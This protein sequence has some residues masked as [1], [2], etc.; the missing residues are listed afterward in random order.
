M[1]LGILAILYLVII[2]AVL[3]FQI[4]LYKPNTKEENKVV[5]FGLNIIL[6]FVL[7]Y[8]VYS[9]LPSNYTIQKVLPLLWTGLAVIAF[10]IKINTHK[11]TML[12]KILLTLGLAGN[13]VQLLM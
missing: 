10:M 3:G 6:V 12:A 7:S 8:I 4:L 13:L 1:A 2:I 9:A 11:A 5:Y